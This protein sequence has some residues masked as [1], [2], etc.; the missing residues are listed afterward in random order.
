MWISHPLYFPPLFPSTLLYCQCYAQ[1]SEG[2]KIFASN[3]T[4]ELLSLS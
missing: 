3:E 2:K 4:K 1:L